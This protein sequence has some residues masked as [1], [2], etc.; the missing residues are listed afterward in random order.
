MTKTPVAMPTRSHAR[1]NA[2]PASTVATVRQ[3]ATRS[4]SEYFPSISIMPINE[5]RIAPR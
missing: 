4:A 3:G 5:K 1:K 2:V